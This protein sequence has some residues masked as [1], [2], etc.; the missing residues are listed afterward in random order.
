M[1]LVPAGALLEG[2]QL[3]EPYIGNETKGPQIVAA[4]VVLLV[5]SA[6]AVTLRFISRK[7]SRAKID[8][9]DYLILSSL[10]RLRIFIESSFKGFWLS[11]LT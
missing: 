1:D 11:R 10:V 7:K 5:L 8:W 2:R 3:C 9:D 6:T 4:N